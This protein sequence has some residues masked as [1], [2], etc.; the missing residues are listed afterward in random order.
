MCYN[1][2]PLLLLSYVLYTRISTLWKKSPL[3]MLKVE[4]DF[5][6]QFSQD[7]RNRR[8]QSK[9]SSNFEWEAAEYDGNQHVNFYYDIRLS[10][11]SPEIKSFSSWIDW[12]SRH[13]NLH[14]FRFQLWTRVDESNRVGLVLPEYLVHQSKSTSDKIANLEFLEIS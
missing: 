2:Q 13:I 10:W 8:V 4:M 1:Y 9:C 7:T 11:W 14:N 6:S 5:T 12:S 3:E